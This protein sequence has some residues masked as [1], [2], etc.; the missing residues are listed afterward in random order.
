MRNFGLTHLDL[1]SMERATN[2][3]SLASVREQRVVRS[4]STTSVYCATPEA[5]DQLT[6]NVGGVEVVKFM[7]DEWSLLVTAPASVQQYIT[8]K[9]TV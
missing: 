2:P 8:Q 1:T 3:R 7:L 5:F 9:L 4:R 6:T